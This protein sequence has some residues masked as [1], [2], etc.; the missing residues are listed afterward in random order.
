MN[1][2]DVDVCVNTFLQLL[3][4]EFLHEYFN[5]Q[6]ATNETAKPEELLTSK[7]AVDDSD[8][9][10]KTQSADLFELFVSAEIDVKKEHKKAALR[11]KKRI[12]YINFL[13]LNSLVSLTSFLFRF[14]RY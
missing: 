7:L 12:F 3:C 9:K 14:L 8:S 2:S 13:N 4:D 1:S 10:S 11:L 5:N 6:N